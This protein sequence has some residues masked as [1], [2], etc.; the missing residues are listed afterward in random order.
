MQ[1]VLSMN[2]GTIQRSQYIGQ[3]V[4]DRATTGKHRGA[5][6]I[7]LPELATLESTY[8]RPPLWLTA[9]LPLTTW[10]GAVGVS[11]GSS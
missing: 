6:T 9:R 10:G 5:A 7:A 8:S 3:L 2:H 11:P 4:W 1:S